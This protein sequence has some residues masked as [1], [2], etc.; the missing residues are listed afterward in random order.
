MRSGE[1]KRASRLKDSEA[2]VNNALRIRHVVKDL[3][4]ND[5]VIVVVG[6]RNTLTSHR[7]VCVPDEFW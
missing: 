1:K 2:F 4:T 6:P 3:R 5:A 7:N